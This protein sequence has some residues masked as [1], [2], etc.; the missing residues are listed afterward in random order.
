MIL[1]DEYRAVALRMQKLI[2][3]LDR[4]QLATV[5]VHVDLA[6]NR[7]ENIITAQNGLDLDLK[8]NS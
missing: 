8:D 5:A 1:I 4:L 6:L 2:D 3:E 7:L